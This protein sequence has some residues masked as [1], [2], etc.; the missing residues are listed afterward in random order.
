M[1][2]LEERRD[3]VRRYLLEEREHHRLPALD[4]LL[5]PEADAREHGEATV[6]ELDDLLAAIVLGRKLV[7]GPGREALDVRVPA[8]INR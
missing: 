3:L 5:G 4:E 8:R 7:L 2:L 6:V 1:E